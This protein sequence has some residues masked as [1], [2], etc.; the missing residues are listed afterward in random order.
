MGKEKKG[1]RIEL[2]VLEEGKDVVIQGGLA[3]SSSCVVED[4]KCKR[5]ASRVMRLD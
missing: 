1:G 2:V 4:M 5:D 3:D